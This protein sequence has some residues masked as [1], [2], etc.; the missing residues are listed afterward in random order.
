MESARLGVGAAHGMGYGIRSAHGH[1]TELRADGWGG[2]GYRAGRVNFRL[3]GWMLRYCVA[4]YVN[5]SVFDRDD[6]DTHWVS[7][8]GSETL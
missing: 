2:A 4:V 3:S 7:Q 8:V 6:D 1:G 5:G